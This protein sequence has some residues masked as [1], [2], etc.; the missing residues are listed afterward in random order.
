MEKE[1]TGVTRILQGKMVSTYG[2]RYPSAFLKLARRH[3]SPLEKA[4]T[5]MSISGM[6]NAYGRYQ[7]SRR[8]PRP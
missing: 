8:T 4:E 3:S 1:K 5:A 2:V 6:I 7:L